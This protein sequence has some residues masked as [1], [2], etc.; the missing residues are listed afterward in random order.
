MSN[1]PSYP[2]TKKE[3]K[4][5]RAQQNRRNLVY[6]TL[7]GN[8]SG[9]SCLPPELKEAVDRIADSPYISFTRLEELVGEGYWQ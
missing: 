6:K 5:L 1:E 8:Y 4:A 7:W 9:Y 2:L 3:E